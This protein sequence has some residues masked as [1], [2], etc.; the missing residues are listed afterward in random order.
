MVSGFEGM[1]SAWM[2]QVSS[3]EDRDGAEN[4]CTRWAGTIDLNLRKMR[5]EADKLI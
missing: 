4:A 2:D 3:F 1:A 5:A